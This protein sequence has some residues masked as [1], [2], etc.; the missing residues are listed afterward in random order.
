MRYR[1]LIGALI[2]MIAGAVWTPGARAQ[3]NGEYIRLHVIANSDDEADQSVKHRVRDA[4]LDAYGDTFA[5]KRGIAEAED[6]ISAHLGAIN[7]LA[8]DTLRQN[9]MS[10]TA[11]SEYGLFS[12]PT[13]QYGDCILPAGEYRALRVVLGE[14][15]GANWWCVLFPPLCVHDTSD[16]DKSD[17]GETDAEK[18][19]KDTAEETETAETTEAAEETEESGDPEGDKRGEKEARPK[20]KF[21]IVEWFEDI[22]S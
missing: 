5:A 17:D 19:T 20:V 11:H 1:M 13:R 18:E 10:Y 7:S 2:L 12:F 14:G 21:K 16:Q 8:R 15:A 22:F 9:G 3:C 6:A 4:I